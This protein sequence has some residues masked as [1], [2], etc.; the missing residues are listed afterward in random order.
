M[1]DNLLIPG[2]PFP[3]PNCGET[4]AWIAH[5][6]T[7]ESQG[8]ILVV[9]EDG[10]PEDDEYDGVTES[11]DPD[12]NE[13]YQC[14]ACDAFVKLDGTL[15]AANEVEDTDRLTKAVQREEAIEGTITTLKEAFDR[16]DKDVI[17]ACVTRLS[18]LAKPR[19]VTEK[20]VPRD[21]CPKCSRPLRDHAL[22]FTS[23]A[24]LAVVTCPPSGES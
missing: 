1:A 4:S 13:Y 2:N 8:V 6:K 22:D 18:E 23:Q 17:W 19:V 24:P 14:G 15:Q 5:Y 10:T 3:C 11:Y 20:D 7:P 16:A 21:A 12:P 9:G